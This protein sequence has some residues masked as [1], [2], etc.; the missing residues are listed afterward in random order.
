ML[1]DLRG[2]LLYELRPELFPYQGMCDTE[3]EL[4]SRYY[5][6]KNQK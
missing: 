5:E 1:C 6:R 3:R 2:R 4:W